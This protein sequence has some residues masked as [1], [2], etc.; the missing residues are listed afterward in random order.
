[1][2]RRVVAISCMAAGD[3]A[4]VVAAFL[5]A[6]P[7]AALAVLCGTLILLGVLLGWT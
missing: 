6:G 7:A 1:M 2:N 3:V 5:A 4:G